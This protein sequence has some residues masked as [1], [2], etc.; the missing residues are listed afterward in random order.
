MRSPFYQADI[1]TLFPHRKHTPYVTEVVE[2]I[3]DLI[4]KGLDTHEGISKTKFV[5]LQRKYFVGASV[6]TI[7]EALSRVDAILDPLNK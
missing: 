1:K 7:S 2:H 5:T 3:K 4:A 6:E